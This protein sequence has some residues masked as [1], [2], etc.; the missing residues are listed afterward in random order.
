MSELQRK[1][2]FSASAECNS[3]QQSEADCKARTAQGLRDRLSSKTA[4]VHTLP[5]HCATW[6]SYES[7]I[8]VPTPEDDMRTIGGYS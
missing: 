5:V 6:T 1:S 4:R 8:T 7:T 2:Y 3:E